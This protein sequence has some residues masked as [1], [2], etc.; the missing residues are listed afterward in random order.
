MKKCAR[1]LTLPPFEK[2][3]LGGISGFDALSPEIHAPSLR[4]PPQSPFYKGEECCIH[5]F[6]CV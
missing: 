3:G 5:F 6:V 2:G 1:H 4:S